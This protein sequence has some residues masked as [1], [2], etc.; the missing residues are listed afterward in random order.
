MVPAAGVLLSLFPNR[1]P[2]ELAAGGVEAAAVE[3]GVELVFPKSPPVAA[4]LAAAPNRD[5]PAAGCVLVLLLLPEPNMP[6]P[7]VALGVLAPEAGAPNSDGFASAGFA[8]V[9]PNRLPGVPVPE[10]GVVELLLPLPAL[11][12]EKPEE[13]DC[14]PNRPPPVE[15]GV[16]EAAG[17]EPN[18]EP[19]AGAEE[20]MALFDWPA[21]L[22][23]PKVKD[24]MG[25]P[26]CS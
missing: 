6:P 23:F 15:G 22:A 21:E 5:P 17:A 16:L 10:S 20:V 3:A 18:N 2:E 7:V 8:A 14:P 12:N 4:G 24:M 1:P 19:E 26:G 11:P 25:A 13:A 9:L